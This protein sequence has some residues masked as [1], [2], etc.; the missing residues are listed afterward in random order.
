VGEALR[1][2]PIVVGRADVDGVHGPRFAVARGLV[3]MYAQT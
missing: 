3:A 2:V 1:S